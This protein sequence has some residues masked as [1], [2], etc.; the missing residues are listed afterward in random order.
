MDKPRCGAT[1]AIN[2]TT[3]YMHRLPEH[4]DITLKGKRRQYTFFELN[5]PDADLAAAHSVSR[6]RGG[7]PIR[8]HLSQ[9]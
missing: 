7:V 6:V 3:P 9:T 4:R 1:A 5:P 2:A 8:V